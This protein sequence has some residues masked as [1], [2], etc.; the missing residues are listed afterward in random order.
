MLTQGTDSL[1]EDEFV[2]AKERLGIDFTS[3]ANKDNLTLSLRS[4]SDQSLLNQAADLMVDAVTQPAFDDKTLQRNKK[5]AHHQ[6]KTK[7]SKT[8][9]M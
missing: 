1:S 8:L 3:T 2:A 5:S 9:I 4:L 6:F 7:K